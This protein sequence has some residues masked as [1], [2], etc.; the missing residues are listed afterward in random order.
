MSTY[1][2]PRSARGPSGRNTA[3]GAG[4]ATWMRSAGTPSVRSTSRPVNAELT[5]IA[6][7]VSAA[8]RYLRVCIERVRSVTHS[9]WW[10]GT[11]SWIVVART[12]ARCGGYI[13]SEKWSASNRP[14]SRSA[15][16]RPSPLHAVRIA[17]ESG[18]GHVRTSTSIPASAARIR[19]GP[20]RLVGANATTSCSEPAASTSPPSEPWM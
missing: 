12:P 16:G 18:S 14:S 7:Q 9:G 15:A 17:W 6:S 5:K 13:Q 10:S 3:F 2:V 8:L 19:P 11:R 1:G 20:R 4:R